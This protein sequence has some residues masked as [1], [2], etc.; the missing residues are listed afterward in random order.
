MTR[1]TLIRPHQG[2]REILEDGEDNDLPRHGCFGDV[3]GDDGQ[4]ACWDQAE[5][6]QVKGNKRYSM[7]HY[8][9]TS[10]TKLRMFPFTDLY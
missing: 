4:Q 8:E 5:G 6:N 7:T 2:G 1:G 3:A 10:R 9:R